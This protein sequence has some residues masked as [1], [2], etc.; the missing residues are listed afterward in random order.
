MSE[1]AMRETF[2][3]YLHAW[4]PV[5]DSERRRLLVASVSENVT[6][7][8][9]GTRL[10]GRSGLQ[11]HLA[12]FQQRRAGF[13]FILDGFVEHHDVALADWVMRDPAGASVV[14]GHDMLHF[15]PTGRVSSITGFSTAPAKP[16]E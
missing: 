12:G 6:Y 4:S 15:D 9:A 8:D 3:A 16:S 14:K 11:A 1:Q 5:G 7:L 2:E 10:N 13:N